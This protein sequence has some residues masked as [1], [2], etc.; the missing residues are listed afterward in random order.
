MN[1]SWFSIRNKEEDMAE[2]RDVKVQ[3]IAG[4]MVIS[5]PKDIVEK[6][7]IEKG[8]VMR[9]GVELIGGDY[10]VYYAADKNNSNKG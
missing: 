3:D 7:N 4:T 9:V 2:K 10:V 8:M 6:M 5:I 1:T